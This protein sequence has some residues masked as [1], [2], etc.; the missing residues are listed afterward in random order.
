MIMI[1]LRPIKNREEELCKL[2]DIAAESTAGLA[3][4][5]TN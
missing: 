1:Q 3:Q 4:G 5:E 2:G